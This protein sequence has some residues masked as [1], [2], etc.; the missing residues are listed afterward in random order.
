MIDDANFLQ[1]QHDKWPNYPVCPV[2]STTKKEDG[3]NWPVMGLVVAGTPTVYKTNMFA[4]TTGPIKP[5]LE[6][7]DKDEYDSFQAMVADGWIV[8]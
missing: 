3:S 4:L 2:K 6:S 1:N 7:V 5:Q 8:D